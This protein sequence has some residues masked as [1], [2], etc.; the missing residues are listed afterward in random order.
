[1]YR[2]LFNNVVVIAKTVFLVVGKEVLECNEEE[3]NLKARNIK[4]ANLKATVVQHPDKRWQAYQ[5]ICS[6]NSADRR[7]AL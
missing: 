4:E 2:T 1:L 7:T 3:A 5:K 6:V